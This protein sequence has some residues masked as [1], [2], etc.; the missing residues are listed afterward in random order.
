MY[1]IRW[2]FRRRLWRRLV[3]RRC[4]CRN[5]IYGVRFCGILYGVYG[6]LR[7][8]MLAFLTMTAAAII[9]RAKPRRRGRGN[10]AFRRDYRFGRSQFCPCR[11][12]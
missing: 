1:R 6:R 8:H 7:F 4:P 10:F 12:R 3:C 2:R 5:A 9:I 11:G